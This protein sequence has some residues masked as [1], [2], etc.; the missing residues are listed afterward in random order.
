RAEQ[1]A[2]ER[3]AAGAELPQ[4]VAPCRVERLRELARERLAKERRQ[5]GRG[6]EIAAS[7]GHA[8][9]DRPPARVVTEPGR[10][11]RER[12]EAA[13]R[14][15]AGGSFDGRADQSREGRRYTA[16]VQALVHR[17][18]VGIVRTPSM[19]PEIKH[20]AFGAP[21]RA[22]APRRKLPVE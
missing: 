18:I 12:H 20:A 15:P 1:L 21:P 10:V 6:D 19:I 7:L 17:H 13:E 22:A 16:L 8:A 11:E 14:D 3:A 4:L 9:D 5:L 2:R